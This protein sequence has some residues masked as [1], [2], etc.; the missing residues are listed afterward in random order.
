[1]FLLVLAQTSEAQSGA[2]TCSSCVLQN[3]LPLPRVSRT[4]VSSSV[5]NLDYF[6]GCNEDPHPNPV[7]H[8]NRLDFYI[9]ERN[10]LVEQ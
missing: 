6:I 9:M 3:M 7:F 4:C 10:F 1:M 2:C 5:K 8:V